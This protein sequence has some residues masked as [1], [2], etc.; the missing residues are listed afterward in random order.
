MAR[1]GREAIV[2][3]RVDTMAYR[4]IALMA[5]RYLDVKEQHNSD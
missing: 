5:K 4:N 2:E 1:E 3:A